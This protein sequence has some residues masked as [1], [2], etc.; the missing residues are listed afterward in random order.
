M[1]YV[2]YIAV[3]IAFCLLLKRAGFFVNSGLTARWLI[4]FFLARAALG[5]LNC[6]LSYHYFEISDSLAFHNFGLNEYYQLTNNFN[7]FVHETFQDYGKNYSG[8]LETSHSFWNNLKENVIVKM[9]G[10]LNVFTFRNFY[11]NTLIFNITVFTGTVAF[12]RAIAPHFLYKRLL[13]FCVFLFPSALFFTST[14]HRDGLIWMSLG[15]VLYAV[16]RLLADG[17][18]TK[19]FIWFLMAFGLIFLLRNYLA[20]ILIPG[21]AAWW[22]AEKNER[23][24]ALIFTLITALSMVL[25]FSL[26][27]LIPLADFPQYVMNRQAAFDEISSVSRTYLPLSPLSP[28][29]YGYIKILPVAFSHVFRLPLLWQVSGLTEIPFALEALFIQLLIMIRIVKG[30]Y[31]PVPLLM[32]LSFISLIALYFIGITVPNL[33]A[34]IRYRSIYFQLLYIVL[35]YG[36]TPR[37][38]VFSV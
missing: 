22:M 9:L 3:L 12:Y 33:G 37:K 25:F 21:L 34:I 16:S 14:I 38:T 18:K 20:F 11:I 26:R 19:R 13:A 29:F 4:I 32:F 27:Y 6:Y 7:Y 10:V 30:K 1:S 31:R 35:L 24:T 36:I 2:L 15:V 5:L 23:R 28:D 17:Y 8:L